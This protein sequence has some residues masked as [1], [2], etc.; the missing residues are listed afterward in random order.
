MTEPEGLPGSFSR[1]EGMNMRSTLRYLVLTAALL[2]QCGIDVANAAGAPMGGFIV[3]PLSHPDS[4]F[5]T[6]LS[7]TVYMGFGDRYDEAGLKALP[8]GGIY[9]EPADA[10]HFGETG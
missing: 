6:V 10:N 8:P 2:T 3:M 4:R 9:T 1:D 5:V 7:G